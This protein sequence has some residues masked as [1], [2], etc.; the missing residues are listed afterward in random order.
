MGARKK[1]ILIQFLVESS[2]LSC[3]GGLLGLIIGAALAH[4]LPTLFQEVVKVQPQVKPFFLF[5]AVGSSTFLGV[6]FGL[7]PAIKASRLSPA[8]ALRSE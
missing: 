5:I 8:D 3:L 1:D 4:L 7:Y 6:V 2:V